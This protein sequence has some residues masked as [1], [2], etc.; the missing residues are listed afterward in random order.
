M[1]SGGDGG[2]GRWGAGEMGRWNRK[3]K[4]FPSAPLPPCPPA[5]LLLCSSAP[6]LLC[7][8][9]PLPLCS[10]APLPHP[11]QGL[12]LAFCSKFSISFCLCSLVFFGFNHLG[13]S[14]TTKFLL[15]KLASFTGLGRKVKL[16]PHI[17]N[18]TAKNRKKGRKFFDF[19]ADI[20]GTGLR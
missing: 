1:G 11:S 5:P 18:T 8:S 14:P 10:P 9:A 15:C 7:S 2:R 20:S 17:T 19:F 12:G 3:D 4:D 13:H 16:S 6:L